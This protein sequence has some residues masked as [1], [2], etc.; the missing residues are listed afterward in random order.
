MGAGWRKIGAAVVLVFFLVSVSGLGMGVAQGATLQEQLRQTRDKLSKTKQ[1]ITAKKKDIGTY[2]SQIEAFDREITQKEQEING[3]NKQLQQALAKL[4]QNEK[5]LR[6]AEQELQE[7]TDDLHQRVRGMYQ[8]GNVQYL[9]VLLASN[10]FGDFLNRYEL[11]KRIVARDVDVVEEVEAQK[12]VL[13]EK[14]KTLQQQRTNIA[15]LIKRQEAARYELASRSAEKGQLL[16]ASKKDLSKQQAELE[17]LERQEEA[18]F[19]EI[20]RQQSGSSGGGKVPAATGAYAHPVPGHTSVSS[21]YGMRFHP[22][23]RYN[24]LHTG[25]DFPAPTGTTV[26]ATQSG[27]VI[28]VS[29][30]NAY[31]KVVMIDHGGG[32][33]SLYAHLSSQLVGQGATVSKG[34]A[35]GRVGSTGWSTGPHLHF[36]I[37]VNGNPVNPRG[38]I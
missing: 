25:I 6:Q 13:E 31:G 16:A 20:A 37:R 3:L 2:T 34:Q 28:N 14:K 29:T 9:E 24:K 18:I 19:R 15:A 27:R 21:G 1:Q 35:I 11:L 23:L 36:E 38:Y 17:R 10:S 12:Q 33:V 30:M 32:I 5:E 8:S 22:V 26:V 7:K 4:E